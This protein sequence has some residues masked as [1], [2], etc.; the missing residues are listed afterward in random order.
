MPKITARN[1]SDHVPDRRDRLYPASSIGCAS[2]GLFR[3]AFGDSAGAE[4]GDLAGNVILDAGAEED[5]EVA[6]EGFAVWRSAG[7]GLTQ[8]S[9]ALGVR[10]VLDGGFRALRVD[11]VDEQHAVLAALVGEHEDEGVI[12]AQGAGDGVELGAI[13]RLLSLQRL[14]VGDDAVVKLEAV[15]VEEDAAAPGLIA[16]EQD[17]VALLDG[18]IVDETTGGDADLLARPR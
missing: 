6:G 7:E 14:V 13:N 17:G 9:Q 5:L 18:F 16:A 3:G 8:F 12:A 2:R 11:A 1:P 10:D 4:E 15:L